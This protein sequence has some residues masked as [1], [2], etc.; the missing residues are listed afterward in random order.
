MSRT[1]ILCITSQAG[2]FWQLLRSPV[3]VFSVKNEAKD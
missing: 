1:V 2:L 3:D